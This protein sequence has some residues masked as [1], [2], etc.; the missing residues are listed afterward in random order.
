MTCCKP[1]IGIAGGIGSGKSSVAALFAELGCLVIASDQ[2]NHE[3]LR[4]PEVISTLSAWWGPAILDAAG[5]VDRRAVARIIFDDAEE[6][7]RLE[8]YVY[9]LIAR[10]RETMI[11]AVEGNSAVKA[12]VIDSPLLFESNLARDCDAIVFVDTDDSQRMHRLRESRGWSPD[13]VRQRESWQLPLAE[14]RSR[15]NFVINN[16]GPCEQVRPQVANILDV[17]LTRHS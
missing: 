17:I 13:E 1:R 4:E 15:S 14:K 3:V 16:N 12:I 6:K 10:R 2:L 5:Q 7:Q 11:R 8:R 9:P